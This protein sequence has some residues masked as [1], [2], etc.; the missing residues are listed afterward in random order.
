MAYKRNNL[1][2]T[3]VTRADLAS[4]AAQEAWDMFATAKAELEAQLASQAIV[5]GHAQDGDVFKFAYGS[6]GQGSIGMAIAEPEK[7]RSSGFAG[8]RKPRPSLDAYQRNQ[9]N[10]GYRR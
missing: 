4:P 3:N 7:L 2:W 9:D 1:A 8:L 5:D 6:I 10:G